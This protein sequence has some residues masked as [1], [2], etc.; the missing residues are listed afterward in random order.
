MPKPDAVASLFLGACWLLIASLV[1]AYLQVGRKESG[2]AASSPGAKPSS[3]GAEPSTATPAPRGLKDAM[4][5]LAAGAPVVASGAVVW[6][7]YRDMGPTKGLALIGLGVS[8][9]SVVIATALAML[10]EARR[11]RILTVMA[12]SLAIGV[13]LVILFVS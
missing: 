4:G 7:T 6:G 13:L 2:G 10:F 8:I 9:V 11:R 5:L 1:N 3:P 12:A